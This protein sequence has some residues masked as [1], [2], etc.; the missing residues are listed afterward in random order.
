MQYDMTLFHKELEEKQKIGYV[1]ICKP[2]QNI[3]PWIYTLVCFK[4]Q[5][6]ESTIY[7]GI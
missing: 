7:D 4:M 3:C 2:V 6:F 1:V 5:A